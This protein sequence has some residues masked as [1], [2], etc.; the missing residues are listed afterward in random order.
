MSPG[1]DFVDKDLTKALSKSTKPIYHNDR[2]IGNLVNESERKLLAPKIQTTRET[3]KWTAAEDMLKD[4]KLAS[5][6]HVDYKV[7]LNG[8]TSEQARIDFEN[9]LK[10]NPSKRQGRNRTIRS[11]TDDLGESLDKIALNKKRALSPPRSVEQLG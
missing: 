11:Q 8:K 5:F 1:E 10:N 4:P 3:I 6:V 7:Y 2:A 9:D